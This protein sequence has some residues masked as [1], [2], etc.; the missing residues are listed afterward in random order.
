MTGQPDSASQ[1]A[2][3]AEQNFSQDYT[4]LRQAVVGVNQLSANVRDGKVTLDPATGAA[5]LAALREHAD[6]INNW[7]RRTGEL[8]QHLPMGNNPVGTAMAGKFSGRAEGENMALATVLAQYH[9]A[10]SAATD[11]ID[12]AM[13][14]Y[15]ANEEHISQS[16]NRIS[17]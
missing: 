12:A 7:M 10:V 5:L 8:A 1:P 9:D 16:F 11:A 17:D 14:Q 13:R 2:Q 6:D 15:Q 3:P 4:E